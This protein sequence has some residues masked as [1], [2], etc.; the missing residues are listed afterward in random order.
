MT[1]QELSPSQAFGQRLR[2]ARRTAPRQ[3]SQAELSKRLGDLGV[4]VSRQTL[5]EIEKGNRRVTLDEAL[6]IA[7]AVGVAPVHLMVP[8]EDDEV[9]NPD[10]AEEGVFRS[11]IRLRVAEGIV[12]H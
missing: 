9:L 11:S 1:T 4:P 12:L 8:F 10:A 7:A 2:D 5:I 3:L 6:A